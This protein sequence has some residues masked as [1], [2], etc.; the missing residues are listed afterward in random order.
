M[1]LLHLCRHMRA[2]QNGFGSSKHGRQF[3]FGPYD[4][5]WLQ[6]VIECIADYIF[7]WNCN[8][9]IAL[10]MVYL[11]RVCLNEKSLSYKKGSHCSKSGIISQEPLWWKAINRAVII[12]A[13]TISFHASSHP[14]SV[15]D[16]WPIVFRLFPYSVSPS[17][18]FILKQVEIYFIYK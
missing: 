3:K 10:L 11:F 13:C 1:A 9:E 18:Q 6:S 17:L 16:L 5:L 12:Q 8:V 7:A 15:I 4:I 2:K 14:A